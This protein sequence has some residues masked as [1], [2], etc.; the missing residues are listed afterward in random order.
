MTVFLIVLI[1]IQAT[2]PEKVSI[3]MIGTRSIKIEN[4]TV[5]QNTVATSMFG[6]NA[7][8][9]VNTAENGI[10]FRP[11]YGIPRG[12]GGTRRG[13]AL[14]DTVD[15]ETYLHFKLVHITY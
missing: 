5:Q 3:I 6:A 11:E 8:Q 10:P 14:H 1:Q 12:W 4:P 9:S 7:L 2:R 13:N 15:S